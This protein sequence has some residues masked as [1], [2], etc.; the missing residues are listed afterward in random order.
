MLNKLFN[1]FQHNSREESWMTGRV[2]VL[3]PLHIGNLPRAVSAGPRPSHNCDR[4]QRG[5]GTTCHCIL[6]ARQRRRSADDCHAA[7]V[8]LLL[9]L[10]SSCSLLTD[11]LALQSSCL[12]CILLA[13]LCVCACPLQGCDIIRVC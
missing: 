9:I 7:H 5:A 11:H 8:S 13:E 1:T 10:W 2:Q 4:G 6:L 12:G 3:H